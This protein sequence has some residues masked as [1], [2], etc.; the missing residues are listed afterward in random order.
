M[1]QFREAITRVSLRQR[2]LQ[3]VI[4]VLAMLPIGCA[5]PG[6]PT[7]D[8][9]HAPA[10]AA[11]VDY[12]LDKPAT[13]IVRADDYDRLWNACETVAQDRRFLLER[14][15][16]RDGLLT[17]RPL[18]GGQALE[19]WRRDISD[20][21]SLAESNLATVRRTIE[22]KIITVGDHYEARPKVVV[23]R[24][25]MIEHRVTLGILNRDAF[26]GSVVTGTNDY[27]PAALP[28]T[29]YWYAVRRDVDLEHQIAGDLRR[30]LRPQ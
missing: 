20:P 30:S 1:I 6:V 21:Y 25:A 19:I 29:S 16:Y 8:P 2:G 22:F 24:Q 12:W 5:T 3:M 15:D 27:D 4:G 7:V 28:P 14:R 18:S 26:S 9:S 11:T 23:E 13:E 10:E 17:T